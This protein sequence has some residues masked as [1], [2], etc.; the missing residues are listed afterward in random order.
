MTAM[1][2]E[3]TDSDRSDFFKDKDVEL[4]SFSDDTENNGREYAKLYSSND[5]EPTTFRKLTDYLLEEDP[6]KNVATCGG[7]ILGSGITTMPVWYLAYADGDRAPHTLVAWIVSIAL[8][9]T[10]LACYSFT[11]CA[12][13]FH[14]TCKKRKSKEKLKR[15]HK[16]KFKRKAKRPLSLKKKPGNRPPQHPQAFV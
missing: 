16:E 5:D 6:F 13:I 4:G 3:K 8:T 7:I 9:A 15:K 12:R 14:N 1:E 2:M 10:G 11:N